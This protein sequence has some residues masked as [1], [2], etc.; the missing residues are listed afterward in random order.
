ML[1]EFA[2]LA[3]AGAFSTFLNTVVKGLAI[4][5]VYAIIALG[6][7]IIFKATQVVNFAQGAIAAA[8]GLFVS[9]LVFDKVGDAPKGQTPFTSWRAPFA[10][11]GLPDVGEQWLAM[12][13]VSLVAGAVVSALAGVLLPGGRR[14]LYAFAGAYLFLAV[15]SGF[16]D[17]EPLW[18]VNFL[19]AMAIAAAVGLALDRPDPRALLP[20]I[21]GTVATFV[22]L[23]VIGAIDVG[24]LEWLGNLV[25]AL[26]FGAALGMVLERV[27]IR[28]MIG[29]PLFSMAVIT[30]GLEIVIRVFTNDSV[31]ILNRPIEVPWRGDPF[32]DET[33]GGFRFLDSFYNYSY[34]AIF[35][36]T[37]ISFIAVF[38]FYRSKLGVAMRAVSF[39]Q[40]AAMAQGIKVGQVF[41]IAWAF[42]A[43]LGV[44]GGVF[45]TQPPIDQAGAVGVTTAFVAFRALPAVILG[46]LDSVQGALVG[47]LLIGLAEI[48]AGQYLSQWTTTLGPGYQQ[49]VPYIV[50]LAV[51][52]VRPFGLFG[53]PEIRR[54]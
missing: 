51:L 14:F 17:G 39:D 11:E 33:P 41:A 20:F 44:L 7:V 10:G 46:G 48:F 21:G 37:A 36:A 43:A 53:T 9:F 31:K 38:L 27:A 4:G 13:F 32:V 34:F 12:L 24:W 35:A 52:L 19:I 15:I 47:G 29:E 23:I 28:P 42:G 25:I 6:F 26:V 22:F 54:V 30:L 18:A 2:V 3:Q 5:S 50:M 49:I 40:E 1:A 16:T 45:A 8:G